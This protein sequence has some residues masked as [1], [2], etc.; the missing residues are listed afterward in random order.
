MHN[1]LGSFARTDREIFCRSWVRSDAAT[2]W[3]RARAGASR[4][5]CLSG[6]FGCDAAWARLGARRLGFVRAHGITR[7]AGR[8]V[9]SDARPVGFVRARQVSSSFGRG[10]RGSVRIQSR[11]VRRAG[12]DRSREEHETAPGLVIGALLVLKGGGRG[13]K[14]K[15]PERSSLTDGNYILDKAGA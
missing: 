11:R 13:A 3:A 4:L 5:L 8:R 14:R 6:S 15:P 1:R 10:V 2:T 7:P 9:R 12:S